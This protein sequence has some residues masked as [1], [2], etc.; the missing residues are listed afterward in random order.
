MRID[1]RRARLKLNTITSLSHQM[2]VIIAGFILPR[3]FLQYYGSEV[4]GLVSSITQF[5]GFIALMELGVGAV[6]QSTLYK[7]LAS[8]D[9]IKISRIVKSARKFFNKVAMIFIIYLVVLIIVYPSFNDK[10]GWLYTASLIVIL[11]I[12][13]IAQY[14]FGITYRLLLSADQ[15]AYIPKLVA[16]ITIILNA[17]LSVILIVNGSSIHIVKL[18]SA[19]VL[20]LQ[21]LVFNIYVKR[22]YDIDKDVKIGEEPLKQK[23]NGIAQHIASFVLNNTDIIV[24]TILS[25][26]INVSIYTVYNLVVTGIK[27]LIISSIAGLQALFG[28]MLANKEY[29]S[30]RKRFSQIEW[31]IHTIVTLLF[32][33][34][35]VLIVPFVNVYTK[36]I[37]DANYDQPLFGILITLATAAYCLRL[38]YNIMVLAAGHYKQT[39]T[40][41]IIEMSINILLSV[42]LVSKF[43]LIG[44]AIGTMVAMAY[45]TMYLAYYLA[46]NIINHKFSYF[47]KH[48]IVDSLSMIIIALAT[49]N[50]SLKSLSYL[51]WF[52]LAIKVFIITSVIITIINIIFYRKYFLN[53]I[54]TIGKKFR[55]I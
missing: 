49:F 30:L 26:L 15:R 36:G 32:S 50:I 9:K 18:I 1:N 23:W 41:A 25:D 54:F 4:N 55:K 35:I 17:I 16:T 40:S 11:A 43:G 31:F 34:T 29:N 28:N 12:S 14:F 37:T 46:H 38:P 52:I 44:V 22:N 10:F 42:L 39:Q 27:K 48:I 6:I 33:C 21:P 51:S 24:L 53:I 20:L 45:R 13:L 47:V 8:H 19:I 2:I 3:L 5:L 7:P